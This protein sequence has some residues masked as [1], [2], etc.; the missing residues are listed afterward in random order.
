MPSVEA[1][2]KIDRKSSLFLDISGGFIGLGYH[3]SNDLDEMFTHDYSYDADGA[4]AVFSL[5]V[6]IIWNDVFAFLEIE[7]ANGNAL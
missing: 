6:G 3:D 5:K 7:Q 1:S 4:G 2:Q